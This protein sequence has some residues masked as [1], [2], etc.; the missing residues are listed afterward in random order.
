MNKSNIF[1]LNVAINAC[2]S[3]AEPLVYS[4]SLTLLYEIKDCKWFR[5][6]V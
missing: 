6:N 5:S 2:E 1:I 4:R 3:V